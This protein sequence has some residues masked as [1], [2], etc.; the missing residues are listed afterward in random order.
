[1]S[2]P[3]GRQAVPSRCFVLGIRTMPEA[4]R[5]PS[6]LASLGSACRHDAP[7]FNGLLGGAMIGSPLPWEGSRGYNAAGETMKGEARG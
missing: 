4:S 1:M 7:F 3:L 2:Q 5:S 6:G